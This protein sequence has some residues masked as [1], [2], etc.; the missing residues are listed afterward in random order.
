M[1]DP[2]GIFLED[3]EV[4]PKIVAVRDDVAAGDGEMNI[5][6]VPARGVCGSG[7]ISDRMNIEESE[8]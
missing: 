1:C 7:V 3:A 4:C 6:V 5:I 2:L 8:S